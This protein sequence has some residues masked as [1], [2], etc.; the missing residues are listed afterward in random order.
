MLYNS[1]DVIGRHVQA[2]D[3]AIGRVADL[4]FEDRHWAVRWA[5]IDTGHWLPGRQVL[6]APSRLGLAD[7]RR[8]F[9]VA[10]TRA[11]VAASPAAE[12]DLPVS[13]RLEEQLAAYYQVQPYWMGVMPVPTMPMP[14]VVPEPRPGDPHLRSV[15]AVSGYAIAATDG[16]IG[17]LK[18]LLLDPADWVVR[19]LEIDTG[20]W[21]PGRKVLVQPDAVTEI[22]HLE[23]RLGVR[24]SRAGVE[25]SPPYH[26]SLDHPPGG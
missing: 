6:L 1:H 20:H 4:L 2:A 9:E 8:G 11:Q 17:H 18:A 12:T 19:A 7:P 10:M 15:A 23:R 13:R 22:D 5:V 21:L 24:L 14:T 16:E 3:G 26:P 25:A